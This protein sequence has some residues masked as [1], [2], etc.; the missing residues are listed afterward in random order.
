[1]L[2]AYPHVDRLGKW[3]SVKTPEQRQTWAL[4]IC[5]DARIRLTPARRAVLA[6]LALQRTPVN[7]ETVADDESVRRRCDSSTVYRSLILFNEAQIVR[8]VAAPRKR[9]LFILNVPGENAH[10]LICRR[11]GCVVDLQLP[12]QIIESVQGIAAGLGFSVSSQDHEI[13]GFCRA[14][15]SICKME[16]LP[17]KYRPGGGI[18]TSKPS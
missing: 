7:W 3:N 18:A 8:M 13:H 9:T 1:L 17:S 10:F 12:H 15:A 5:G 16:S 14:C 4:G 2:P 11:C 6:F